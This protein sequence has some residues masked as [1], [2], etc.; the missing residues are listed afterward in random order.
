MPG[1]RIAFTPHP[2]TGRTTE[3]SNAYLH[4][5]DP[6]TGNQMLAE[7]VAGLKDK[8]S[9]KDKQSGEIDRDKRERFLAPDTAENLQQMFHDNLWTDGLPIILPTEEKV[10]EMLK[11]TS[12]KP[13]EIVGEMRPSGPHEA[14]KY[15]VEMVAIN[16]VMAGAKPEYLPVIL[17]LAST[18]QT[19]LVS[20]TSSFARRAIVNGPSRDEIQMN[21]S[22][23]ALGPFNQA[24]SAIG[25]A[26]LLLS[27]NLGGSGTPGSTYL[28]STGNPLNYNNITFPEAEE[29]L[30]EG[31]DPLHVQ[32]GFKKDESVVSI[33][34]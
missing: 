11:G 19:A 10:K 4:G 23:G 3:E 1:L 16:A 24:N 7:V 25:R 15:T 28:G 12:H 22:I 26:W 30:P 9:D 27:K 8:L 32:K 33:M 6:V 34:S 29:G 2:I 17:A 14:W 5:K 20:S 31:W 21:S 13:D 18:G